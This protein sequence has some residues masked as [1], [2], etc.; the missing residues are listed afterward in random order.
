MTTSGE[1]IQAG[2]FLAESLR[3]YDNTIRETIYPEYWGF[4]GRYHQ[5]IGDLPIGTPSYA[6]IRQDFTGRAVR[7]GGTAT[8]IPTAKYGLTMSESKAMI[9]ILSAEWTWD[10]LRRE[11]LAQGNQYL[12]NV[13]VVQSYLRALDKGLREWM[14][15]TTLFGSQDNDMEFAGL[16]TNPFVEVINVL[17][18]D[19]GITGPGQTANDAYDWMRQETSNFRKANKLTAEATSVLTSEDV[20]NAFDK[21]FSDGSGD[22]T[23]GDLLLGATGNGRRTRKLSSINIVNEMSGEE[24]RNPEVGNLTEIGGVPIAADADIMLMFDANVRNSIT[25]KFAPIRNLPQFTNDG[26]LT[27]SVYGMCGVGEVVFDQPMRAR[28]FVLNKS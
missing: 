5:A 12:P 9:G 21:R 8:A 23:V 4:E 11:E 6:T 26:G 22:G 3:K 19:N 7:Y 14:H 25:K 20:N 17:A 15:Y 1:M 18:A 24:I 2:N 27:Y 13:P 16:F 28:M 10:E